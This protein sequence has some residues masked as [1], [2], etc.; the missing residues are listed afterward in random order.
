MEE[1]PKPVA[2][3]GVAAPARWPRC[4]SRA[5]VWP[6]PALSKKCSLKLS[7]APRNHPAC[8]AEWPRMSASPP[9][10]IFVYSPST[11]TG[12]QPDGPNGAASCAG[13]EFRETG[14]G[15]PIRRQPDPAARVTCHGVHDPARAASALL[16]RD[17]E[18]RFRRVLHPH[19]HP[20]PRPVFRRTRPFAAAS[21]PP[22]SNEFRWIWPERTLSTKC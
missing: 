14:V 3:P 9:G 19:V 8:V 12:S 17:C 4:A 5:S 21:C 20:L 7:G 1:P 18:R 13:S 11:S 22:P 6:E 16:P 15:T 2:R 10:P